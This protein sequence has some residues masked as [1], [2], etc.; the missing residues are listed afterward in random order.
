MKNQLE[1]EE[2]EQLPVGDTFILGNVELEVVVQ[3][4]CTGCFLDREGIYCTALQECGIRPQCSRRARA[5]K[6]QVIFREVEDGQ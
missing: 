6:N 3:I 4:G 5:D 1:P 2:F